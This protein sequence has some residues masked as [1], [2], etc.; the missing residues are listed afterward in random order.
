MDDGSGGTAPRGDKSSWL[1]P[2]SLYTGDA[3][4]CHIEDEIKEGMSGEDIVF[5]FQYPIPR[6]NSELPMS[7]LHQNML[8]VVTPTFDYDDGHEAGEMVLCFAILDP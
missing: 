1:Y 4:K 3:H 7:R 6:E 5:A 2:R 8:G